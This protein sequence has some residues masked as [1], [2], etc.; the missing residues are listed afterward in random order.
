MLKVPAAQRDAKQNEKLAAHFKS[1]SPEIKRL[2]DAAGAAK[3]AADDFANAVPVTSVMVELGKPRATHRHIR[4]GYLALAEEVQPGTPAAQHPF[5]KDAP[6]SRLGLA[7]WIV[8]R[9][10]P[11]TAR[12]MV[13]RAWEQYFGRGIVET[14]EEFWKQGE[15][16]RIS[17]CSTGSRGNSWTAAGETC[18]GP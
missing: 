10:N 4:G 11:L 18:R 5:P 9:E 6:R 3:K 14:V 7:R 8:D 17:N 2:A 13:N 1:I 16:L 12:V 15:R